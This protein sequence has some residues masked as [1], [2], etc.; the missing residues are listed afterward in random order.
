[1]K[2]MGTAKLVRL[3][4]PYRVPLSI[5]FAAM[6]IESAADLLEPWPLKIIFDYVIGSKATPG[7]LGA[8]PALA[9]TRLALL[10]AAAF[11]VVVIALVGAASSY[12][13]KFLSTSVGQRVTRDLRHTLYHHLQ[14][15]SLSFYEKQRTGDMVVRLTSDIDAVQDL[16]STVL[17][18]MVLNALTLAG[19]VSVMLYLDWRFTF[20][21]LSVAPVLFVLVYRL[22][23]RIKAA[24]RAVK[25]KESDLA[26]VVQEAVSSARIVKA[27]GNE[28]YEERR[29]DRESEE[30]LQASLRARSVKARLSPLID[31]VV[32]VGTFLVLFFGVRH[33]ISGRLSAG[34]LIVFVL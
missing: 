19:M 14:R 34:A 21:A 18:G 26:S 31:V 23:R 1:M 17:L 12:T 25:E 7:W 15:L 10:N 22:T 16:V 13:E 28:D 32:A 4:R 29:L 11:A 2:S 5:A 9:G 3:L 27:F 20:V 24:A 30:S 6:L 8:W 33:V